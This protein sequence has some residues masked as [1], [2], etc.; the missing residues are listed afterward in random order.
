MHPNLPESS[1]YKLIVTDVD[2]TLLNS[3]M[4]LED[5]T[6][7]VF[8][9]L[10]R[11]N[12][13]ITLATGKNYKAVSSLIDILEIN[14]PLILANGAM[15]KDPDGKVLFSKTLRNELMVE[16]IGVCN[17][18]N[19]DWMIYY[20][21]EIL[22]REINNNTGVTSEYNEPDPIRISDKVEDLKKLKEPMK[23][24]IVD[25]ENP[26][27]LQIVLSVLKEKLKDELNFSFSLG[28]FLEIIPAGVSK[29]SGVEFVADYSGIEK[30]QIIAFGDEDNDAGMLGYVGLGIAV[31]N[32]SPKCKSNAKLI[33]GHH[34][35]QGPAKFLNQFYN[36]G[37][38]Y[39]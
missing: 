33:I 36:L 17:H 30:D 8:R 24:I 37:I 6:V 34:N 2:E 35:E 23:L 9:E 5:F 29:L 25:R 32:G 39:Q 27:K 12:I 19:A 16:I 15:I 28:T 4:V 7:D 20:E 3:K 38:K 10:K 31:E 13:G 1:Q 22:V 21:K 14:M 18:Y 11:K 26:Q